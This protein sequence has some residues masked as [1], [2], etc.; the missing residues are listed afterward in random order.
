MDG[1]RTDEGSEII[2]KRNG[3]EGSSVHGAAEDPELKVQ[4]EK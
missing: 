4:K 2:R 1:E 3:T